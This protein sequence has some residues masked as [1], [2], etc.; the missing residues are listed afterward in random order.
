MIE[1]ALVDLNYSNSSHTIAPLW[2]LSRSFAQLQCLL[3]A[4]HLYRPEPQRAQYELTSQE[5]PAYGELMVVARCSND[6]KAFAGT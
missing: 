4:D 1:V 3:V 2:C 5:A 6:L